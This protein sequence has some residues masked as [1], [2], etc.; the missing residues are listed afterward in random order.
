MTQ[1]A[2]IAECKHCRPHARPF[3]LRFARVVAVF[4]VCSPATLQA[5][6]RP[7]PGTLAAVKLAPAVRHGCRFE[8]GTVARAGGNTCAPL[9]ARL[10]LKGPAVPGQGWS[11]IPT[12]PIDTREQKNHLLHSCR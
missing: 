3:R 12:A 8:G 9:S 4:P 1:Q 10:D 2:Q 5:L 6:R 7:R 11:S